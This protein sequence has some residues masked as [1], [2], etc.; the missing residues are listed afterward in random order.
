MSISME[1]NI[2]VIIVFNTEKIMPDFLIKLVNLVTIF[3]RICLQW[4]GNVILGNV[5]LFEVMSS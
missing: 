2:K 4:M 5:I 3:L 1:V